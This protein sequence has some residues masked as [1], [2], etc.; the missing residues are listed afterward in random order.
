M[1]RRLFAFDIDGT[2]LDSN[3][4]PLDSTRE[5]LDKL[6]KAGHLVTIATGRSRFHA[7]EIIRDLE[8][9]NYILCNGAAGFLDHEQIYKNLLDREQLDNFV[10]QAHE[11]QIDTAFV[12]LDNI[13]RNSSNHVDVMEDAMKSFGAVLPELDRF[14]VEEQEVYQALAFFDN[15][16]DDKFTNYERL[17]FVRWHENSVDVVPHNG[18]KAATILH[19]AEQVGIA[20]E[21]VISFGDGQNDREMLRMSGVGVAMGNAVPEVQK[22]AD[23]VTDTNDQD[24]IWKTL[25]EMSFI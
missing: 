4:Q 2:L 16:F 7:Q 5:A 22:E 21:D 23:V 8:F 6:R 19:L 20:K 14:F 18:S 24:G 25:K 3:K 1:R 15:T 13:K 17:R 9:T 12:G 10:K 11:A